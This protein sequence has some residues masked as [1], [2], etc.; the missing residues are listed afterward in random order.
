M[1]QKRSVVARQATIVFCLTLTKARLA[2]YFH[3]ISNIKPMPSN[4]KLG[5]QFE[6][7]F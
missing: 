3:R 7:A 1:K 4:L 5:E 2:R 6:Q